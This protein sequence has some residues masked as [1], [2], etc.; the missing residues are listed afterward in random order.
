MMCN[1]ARAGTSG[2][3]RYFAIPPSSEPCAGGCS[4]TD[5]Q[6]E[7]NTLGIAWPCRGGLSQKLRDDRLAAHQIMTFVVMQHA[8]F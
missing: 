7:M 4:G 2:H 5:Y 1:N 6:T 3:T 8:G